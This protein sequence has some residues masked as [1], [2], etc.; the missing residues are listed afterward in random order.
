VVLTFPTGCPGLFYGLDENGSVK[1]F[2]LEYLGVYELVKGEKNF[3]VLADGVN[4]GLSEKD[5]EYVKECA[6]TDPRVSR[7]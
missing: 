5:L 2:S 7:K 4:L 3:K 6:L 1:L